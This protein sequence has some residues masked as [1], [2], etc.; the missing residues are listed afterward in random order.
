[1]NGS[2]VLSDLKCSGEVALLGARIDGQVICRGARFENPNGVA[3]L[4]DGMTV[5]DDVFFREGFHAIGEVR[6]IG[7]CIEGELSCRGA[8]FENPN[9]DALNAQRAKVQGIVHL[10]DLKSNGGFDFQYAQVGAILDD[11]NSWPQ[12]GRL[13]LDGLEYE[14]FA[15]A[16]TPMNA[17]RRIEWLRRQPFYRPQPYEQLAGVFRRM[18]FEAEAVE[19]LIAKQEDLI[20]YGRL[21]WW[22]KCWRWILG[23]T[24]AHGYRS[25][26]ALLWSLGF[27]ISGWLIFGLAYAHGLM[28]PSSPAILTDSFY[29]ASGATPSGYPRFQAPAYSLDAFL[30]I[31]N[32]HQEDFWLP[33]AG[34]PFGAFIRFYLWIHILS[35][36]FLSTLFVS[37]VTGLVRR[38]Q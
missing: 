23:L 3:L 19:V 22:E 27:V 10:Q 5:R 20:R 34:K 1:M 6:L 17:R 13:W 28:A 26:R 25:S 18:G 14:G 4:A 15:G 35:G 24:I 21:S 31:V 9:G 32:L 29:R 30:P 12:R 16:S 2:L 37:G 11:E 38:L 36:W 33:D 8:R 7:A